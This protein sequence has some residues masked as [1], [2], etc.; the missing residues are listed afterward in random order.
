M[1]VLTFENVTV[2]SIAIRPPVALLQEFFVPDSFPVGDTFTNKLEKGK[3]RNPFKPSPL[4]GGD[5]SAHS[6]EVTAK[7]AIQEQR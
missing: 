5:T 3:K 7:G 1:T 2:C 6:G 4:T